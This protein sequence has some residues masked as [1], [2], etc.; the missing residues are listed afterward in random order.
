MS[1]LVFHKNDQMLFKYPLEKERLSI[2]R[3]QVNDIV[4][5]DDGIS[6]L[7]CEV[8]NRSGKLTIKDSS[9]NGTF[10]NNI[11]ID[12][13]VFAKKDKLKIGDWTI[14]LQ[15]S[16]ADASETTL[17]K[18]EEVTKIISYDR[19]NK[20][21]NAEVIDLTIKQPNGDEI[22]KKSIKSKLNIGTAKKMKSL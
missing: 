6:R 5:A 14:N 18:H 21:L 11:K 19:E 4:L 12:R 16:D 20:L 7:H 15:V 13:K 1:Y 22:I 8:F 2:G 10:I 9:I 3:D 17:T